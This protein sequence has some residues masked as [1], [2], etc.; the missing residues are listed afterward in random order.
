M[1][2][3]GASGIERIIETESFDEDFDNSES[4]DGLDDDEEDAAAEDSAFEEFNDEEMDEE[5][6][7]EKA[8]FDAGAGDIEAAD[9]T[10]P[11][12][13]GDSPA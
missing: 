11:V 5:I 13:G 7:A 10:P 2:I 1:D 9:L 8:D 6:S 3:S 12:K 4:F